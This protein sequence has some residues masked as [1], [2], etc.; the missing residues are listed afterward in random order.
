[1]TAL[2][3]LIVR[4]PWLVVVVWLALV[5]GGS[6]AVSQIGTGYTNDFSTP[7]TDSQDAT[8]LLTRSFPSVSGDSDTLVW[9]IASGGATDSSAKASIEPLL[10]TIAEN[11]AVGS[12]VSPF[13]VIGRDAPAS[14]TPG[15]GAAR[16]PSQVSGDGRTAYAKIQYT[17]RANEVDQD[18]IEAV[19]V[20][21]ER[22]KDA[23]G[24]GKNLEIGLTGQVV[25]QLSQPEV[26]PKELIGVGFAL[27]VMLVAFGSLLAAA[28][29]IVT[30]VIAL[31]TGLAVVGLVSNAYELPT[32]SST[33]AVLLGLGVGI[34]YALFLV[35]RFRLALRAGRPVRDAVTQAVD[36]SGRAVLFAG[37]TVVISV[38]G[39]AVVG[40]DFTTGLGIGTAIVVL[41]IMLAAVTLLPALLALLGTRVLS[42]RYRADL[43]EG[44]LLDL[45]AH[46]QKP[47][48]WVGLLR[49]RPGL[50]ALA[51]AAV[52][53]TLAAPVLDLRLGI[54]DQGNDSK[55]SLTR[56]G[57]DLLADG[58]GPGVNGPLLVAVATD[59]A[60]A[61]GALTG[62]TARLRDTEGVAS[63]ADA[64]QSP[65]GSAA[66][67]EVLPTTGPQEEATVDTI[68]RIR[69]TVIPD[70]ERDHP[71]LTAHVGGNTAGFDDFAEVI[72]GKLPLFFT[73]IIA[74]SFLL[75]VLAFRSLVIPA[76]GAAMNVL[77][78]AAAFGVV[79]AV[80][81]WGWGAELVGVGKN[82]PVEPFIPVLAFAILFGLSMDYQV[83]LVSRMHEEWVHSRDNRR[84]VTV[85]L[86]ET[87]PVI[88]SA[89][90]IMI[91][92]FTSFALGDA[93]IIK[94]VGIGLAIGVLLDA[95]VL[96]QTLVPGLMYVVGRA[97]WWLPAWLDRI[98]P[99]VSIEGPSRVAAT[100]DPDDAAVSA[101][102]PTAVGR[103][104]PTAFSPG[105]APPPPVPVIANVMPDPS[106]VEPSEQHRQ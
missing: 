17:K 84:A 68:H 35:N 40:L 26:G 90:L 99:H 7:G 104:A 88:T 51:G 65:D 28:L 83:F 100:A 67:I 103:D 16:G 56:V 6:F 50:L 80:F 69:D 62:L 36:T 39:M 89:A 78:A 25:A 18:R 32:T 97:N 27:I 22:V 8:D 60:D 43:R 33:L 38:L 15:A 76:L 21:V 24:E 101:G 46:H 61:R 102:H 58:F 92:V 44:R 48:R 75:L 72:T 23:D 29:P 1:M 42:R 52:M 93:R 13:G 9:R 47:T 106:A 45:D 81:Q 98:L 14:G 63:V 64:R 87:R 49:R 95:F 11:P 53:L 73:A 59:D 94:L 91:F 77:G 54:A 19:V 3:R 10:A 85:G 79:V 74:L 82:G 66:L 5:G 34:D 20:A 4:V 96:R 105:A 31:G 37:G 86:S 71:G 57:Y 41:F 30:A 55:G 70:Q 2:A 12:V